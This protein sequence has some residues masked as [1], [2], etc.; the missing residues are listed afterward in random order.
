[1]AFDLGKIKENLAT[2]KLGNVFP[3]KGQE[4]PT[5]AKKNPKIEELKTG[6][7]D[8]K[9]VFAEG[10]FSLFVKQFVVLAGVFLLVRMV[11]GKLEAHKA[12]LKD[13]MAA[14]T[15]QQTN[16]ED[17]LN[18]KEHLLRLEPLFPDIEQKSN[19]LPSRLMALFSKH[20]LSPKIDGNFAENAKGNLIVV[21]Q[22]ISWQQGYKKLGE[23]M[24][25]L[26]N[27]DDFLRVS[28]VSIAKLTGKEVLGDNA[29]TVRFNT[30]FPKEKYSPKLF[31]DYK[32]RMEK[33]NAEKQAAAARA[34]SANI[35]TEET[36]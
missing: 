33:I 13:K 5:W 29:V 2:G 27:G 1:M 19:W 35:Q 9:N 28:E 3:K 34:A 36:K 24:A 16:K 30:V 11:N 32:Q 4:L 22:P 6:L 7:Q 23:M 14:I 10:K 31:K 15:I 21:S 18:N 26:E 17:Y 12:T 20:D 25:D 8:I